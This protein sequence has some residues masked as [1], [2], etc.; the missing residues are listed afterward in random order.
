MTSTFTT[1]RGFEKPANNDYVGTWDVPVNANW[2]EIDASFGAAV[3][4]ALSSTTT[5]LSKAQL[6]CSVLVFTGALASPSVVLLPAAAGGRFTCIN[7][8]T[9]SQL[10]IGNTGGPN[11]IAL[12][13]VL[14]NEIVSDGNA[15]YQIGVP[16][17]GS[18]RTF[19]QT[20]IPQGWLYCDGTSYLTA[21]YPALFNAIQYQYGGSGANFNV[22]DVRGRVIP[23]LDSSAGRLAFATAAG[24]VAGEQSHLLLA[25]E[26]P[27]HT[28]GYSGTTGDNNANH[29]HGPAIGGNFVVASSGTGALSVPSGSGVNVAGATSIQSGN[30]QHVY[31][32]N[33]DGGT[34][35]GLVHNNIQPSIAMP[36]GIKI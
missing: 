35:G 1:N 23:C 33:T 3:T 29:N 30:H 34:G 26:M 2:D 18:V 15:V 5:T 9:G 10:S 22:P 28:H 4:V 36:V 12:S 32:G 13:N 19:A 25:T 20:A 31:S 6:R 27:S 14:P 16:E 24:A 8:T 11:T 21:T 7:L 17:P